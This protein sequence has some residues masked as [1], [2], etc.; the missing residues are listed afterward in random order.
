MVNI[1]I[2]LFYILILHILNLIKIKKLFLNKSILNN[3]KQIERRNN[4]NDNKKFR[5]TTYIFISYYGIVLLK[6]S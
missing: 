5:Q 2:Y 1:S 6:Q 4:K 3:I